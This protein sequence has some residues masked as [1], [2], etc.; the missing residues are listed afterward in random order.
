V[1]WVLVQV[2]AFLVLALAQARAQVMVM[3]SELELH[4]DFHHRNLGTRLGLWKPRVRTS[5]KVEYPL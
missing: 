5:Y 1:D 2:E 3:E 4:V